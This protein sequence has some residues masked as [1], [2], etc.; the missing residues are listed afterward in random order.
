MQK[1]LPSLSHQ[2]QVRRLAGLARTALAAYALPAPRLR[3]LKQSYNT[4][5]RVTAANSDRYVLRVHPPGKTSMDAVRS[6]LLWLTAL[7]S[8]TGL[9]VPEPVPNAE[10][11]LV[12]VVAHPDFPEPRLC[13]LF[14]WMEGRFLY[15]GLT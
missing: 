10:Q 3:L 11:S 5:F 12:T 13:V 2:G 8:D 15:R 9:P 7:R 1:P 14:R 6:E 4:T